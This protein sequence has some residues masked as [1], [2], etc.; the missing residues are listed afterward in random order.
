MLQLSSTY[1][2][3]AS[4]GINVISFC[5]RN[6]ETPVTSFGAKLDVYELKR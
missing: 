4:E 5:I 6:F 1:I 2:G 3:N